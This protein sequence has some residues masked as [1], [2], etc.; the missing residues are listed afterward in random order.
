MISTNRDLEHL[1]L[2]P[3][4]VGV[5]VSPMS[6]Y[7]HDGKNTPLSPCSQV[8]SLIMYN[9]PKTRGKNRAH[10]GVYNFPKREFKIELLNPLNRISIDET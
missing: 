7:K 1:N 9:S 2:G 5:G 6:A 8:S 4:Q 3:K 10:L